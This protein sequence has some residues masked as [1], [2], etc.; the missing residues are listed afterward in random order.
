[1]TFEIEGAGELAGVADGNPHNVDRFQQPRRHTWHGEALAILRPAKR[2]GRVTLTA[3]ASRLR[4]AR[5]ALPV[6]E[7]GA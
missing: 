2:P 6:T 4:P 5:L 7:A 3:K 1:M